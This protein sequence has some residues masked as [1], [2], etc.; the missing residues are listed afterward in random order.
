MGIG[1][2]Y[3]GQAG[4]TPVFAQ[5]QGLPY[6]LS[7]PL[8][9]MNM[10]MLGA[11]YRG[12]KN[13]YV[14]V[15]YHA[16]GGVSHG[17]FDDDLR[18][19]QPAQP[20]F[21]QITGLYTNRTKPIAC[22]GRQRRYQPVEEVA[23][24]LSPDLILEHFG[25]ETRE[26]LRSRGA[27]STGSGSRRTNVFLVAFRKEAGRLIGGPLLFCGSMLWCFP[28]LP[29]VALLEELGGDGVLVDGVVAGDDGEAAV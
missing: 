21:S 27:W 12:P 13:Q 5:A 8:V 18:P 20:T 1:A 14:A 3:R 29:G 6:N 17:T 10:G 19:G 11:Q 16:Y 26:F 23:I 28:A 9:Y 2:E 15:N 25:T 22:T 7:R 24:R 4:T